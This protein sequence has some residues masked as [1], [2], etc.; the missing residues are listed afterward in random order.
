MELLEPVVAQAAPR[1]IRLQPIVVE[2]AR[3]LQRGPRLEELPAGPPGQNKHVRLESHLH[4]VNKAGHNTHGLKE[5]HQVLLQ[6]HPDVVQAAAA[7]PQVVVAVAEDLQE[8]ADS[9]T[10]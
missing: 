1:G 5:L 7:H 10:I 2:Q 6:G 4:H 3:G 8:E 9:F